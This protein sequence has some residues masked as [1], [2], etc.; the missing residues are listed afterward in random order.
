MQT[1]ETSRLILREPTAADAAFVLALV[2]DPDWLRHI[3]DRG[4]TSLADARAYIEAGPAASVR[5]H[6]FGLRLVELRDGRVPAGLCG[7]IRR[8]GLDD[9]DLGFAFLPAH[10][11]QGLAAEAAAVTLDDAWRRL[12]MRRVVA[13]VSADNA[14]SVRLLARLGFALDGPTTVG[15]DRVDLYRLDAPAAGPAAG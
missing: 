10:R 4:V 6:G 8:D 3:G 1:V 13:I 2:T 15:G 11:G 14:A 7:L 5:R 9:A 12:G